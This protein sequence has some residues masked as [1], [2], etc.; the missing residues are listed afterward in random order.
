AA[1]VAFHPVDEARRDVAGA[2]VFR[3]DA[4]VRERAVALHVEDADVRLLA[5]VAVEERLVRREAKAVRLAEV[6]PQKLRVAPAGRSPEKTLKI[7]LLL[8]LHAEDGHAPIRRI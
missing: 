5:V 3:E 6:V 7:E 1:L 4:A 8:A 2:D